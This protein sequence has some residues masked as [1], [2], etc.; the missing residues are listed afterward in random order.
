MPRTGV[1][2]NTTA[3]QLGWPETEQYKTTLAKKNYV[4]SHLEKFN[5]GVLQTDSYENHLPLTI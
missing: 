4:I 5:Y 1:L 3:Y 2:L